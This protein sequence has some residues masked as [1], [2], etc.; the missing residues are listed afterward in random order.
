M[1]TQSIVLYAFCFLCTTALQAQVNVGDTLPA[2]SEGELDIHTINTG[3]GE[4]TLFVLPDGTTMLVDAGA[5]VGD[6]P[7]SLPRSRTGVARPRMDHEIHP[8]HLAPAGTPRL[9]YVLLTHFHDD[10]L[11]DVS[12]ELKKSP[13]GYILS[14][15]TEVCESLP[16]SKLVDRGWPDYNW[17]QPFEEEY[18]KN[19]ILFAKKTAEKGVPVEAFHAGDNTQFTLVR[20]PERYPEFEIRNIAVN[21]V[22]WTGVNKNTRNHFPSVSDLSPQ[23][24]PGENMCSAAFRLSYGKFDYFNG[25]DITCSDPG[26][27]R[28]IE[29]PSVW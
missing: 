19:Y 24:Y 12:P 14:G 8:P 18:V 6:N 21:G 26:T 15:I 17:P 20:Q 28:D 27:W 25:G 29:T 23:E 11:G 1:K 2:R 4:C 5:L 13:A 9:D 3:K 16:F 10:H 22:V 7:R